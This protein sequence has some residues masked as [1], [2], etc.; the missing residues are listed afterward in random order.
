MLSE[1]RIDDLIE[2]GWHVLES[3]FDKDAFQ[4]WRREAFKFLTAMLGPEHAYTR[5]FEKYVHNYPRAGLLTGG[6]ILSAAKEQ[7]GNSVHFMQ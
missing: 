5:Y 7:M 1:K 3:D 2:A 6:G 4:S